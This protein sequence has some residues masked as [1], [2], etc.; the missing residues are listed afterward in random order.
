MN[1]L[2]QG[3]PA[4]TRKTF[5]P[6]C[7]R[8][9]TVAITAAPLH[10]GHATL[11]DAGEV[12]C[13]DFGAQCAGPL[14]A[15]FALPR[16]VM[17]VRLARSGLRPERLPHVNAVCDGCAHLVRMEVVDENHAHCPECGT[18]NI[19]TLVRLDGE[20]WVAVTGKRAELE[21]S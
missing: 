14:C 18:V 4:E 20:E 13:L 17:G 11:P 1:V 10:G 8:D 9:V 15:A 19:W 21:L 16:V 3:Q 12:V 7:N 6:R 2:P 5:C